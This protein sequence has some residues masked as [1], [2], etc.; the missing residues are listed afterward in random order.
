MHWMQHLLFWLDAVLI[1]TCIAL[2]A[3][4]NVRGK[5]WLLGFLILTL[6]SNAAHYAPWLILSR[7]HLSAADFGRALE[8][9]SMVSR[10]LGV[11]AWASLI[12]FV[13]E[14]RNWPTEEFRHDPNPVSEMTQSRRRR[15]TSLCSFLGGGILALA[16]AFGIPAKSLVE[17]MIRGAQ[18][19][20]I[21]SF[22]GFLAAK[23]FFAF[24]KSKP[25]DQ[26]RLRD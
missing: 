15:I 12:R 14:L 10:L 23:V 26:A 7:E 17:A 25:E 20:I 5:V 19:G 6:C 1:G 13:F 9:M 3:S 24:V 22:L 4:S 21:G 16:V 18:A 11:L 2:A 8:S